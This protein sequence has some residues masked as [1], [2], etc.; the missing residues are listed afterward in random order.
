MPIASINIILSPDALS[1]QLDAPSVQTDLESWCCQPNLP[2]LIDL[3]GLR[4]ADYRVDRS[5]TP[6]YYHAST[7]LYEVPSNQ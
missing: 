4:T 5:S 3:S 1:A 6:I 7:H 2:K